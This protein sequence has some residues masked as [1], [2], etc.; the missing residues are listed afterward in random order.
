MEIGGAL[1]TSAL[2][3][4]KVIPDD[5]DTRPIP[6]SHRAACSAPLGPT[7]QKYRLVSECTKITEWMAVTAQDKIMFSPRVGV[8][9]EGLSSAAKSISW[10]RRRRK[11]PETPKC[12]TEWI[13]ASVDGLPLDGSS[14]SRGN[15][16]QP[17]VI[18]SAQLF[19]SQDLAVKSLRPPI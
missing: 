8:G 19:A 7:S 1:S 10:Y 15:C 16:S 4:V 11:G 6:A 12:Y 17:S 5:A 9:G 3:T 13:S 18:P 2:T 14:R